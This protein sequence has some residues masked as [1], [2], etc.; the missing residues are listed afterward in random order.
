[1][2]L[3]QILP[4]S[5]E[6][7]FEDLSLTL[8]KDRSHPYTFET[9]LTVPAGSTTKFSI[10]VKNRVLKSKRL[11]NF[12]LF[13]IIKRLKDDRYMNITLNNTP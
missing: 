6:L 10:Q 9:I 4:A 5:K 2:K 8:A 3:E 11:Q 1:M 13:I 7:S 12:S